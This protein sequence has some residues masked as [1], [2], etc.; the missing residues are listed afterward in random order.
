[1]HCALR[2]E[3]QKTVAAIGNLD[4]VHKGHQILLRATVELA[5]E[6]SAPAAVIDFEPHP[7]R[8]FAPYSPPF[9]LTKPETK[10]EILGD[11]GINF[12]LTLPF[13]EDLQAQSPDTFVTNTLRGVLNLQGVLAGED[14][15]FGAKRSGDI[16]SLLTLAEQHGMR[17]KAISPHIVQSG[18]K[19]SSS[20]IRE[21]VRSG[22][23][24]TAS[25]MLGRPFVIRGEV[26]EGKKLARTINFP[27][28]NISLGPYVR[29]R[30]GV[31]VISTKLYG[32]D[33]KG[34]ANIGKR[35][36]VDG[37]NEWLEAHF[38]DFEGDLYGQTLD[39]NIHH[40]LRS[41]QKFDGL[42]DLKAQIAQ[43][44]QAAKQWFA[45]Q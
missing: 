29:P 5:N 37:E 32:R 13:N 22:N 28:A 33:I 43:D 7:R 4:G 15:R 39:I 8:V 17:A 42:D 1:M 10:A 19:Y 31:Y 18:E 11:Y 20:L 23:M 30:Y 24:K 44:A 40:F 27:T 12:V 2:P 9:L 36:T 41:E 6:M 3:Y 25:D 35:P 16:H 26:V 45:T 21:S 34:V 14:F 38:F